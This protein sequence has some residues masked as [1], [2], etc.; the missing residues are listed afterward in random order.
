MPGKVGNLEPVDEFDGQHL[1]RGQGPVHVGHVEV[2]KIR[3]GLGEPFH[4][5]RFQGEIQF[6]DDGALELFADGNGIEDVHA[7]HVFLQQEREVEHDLQIHLDKLFHARAL[8]LHRHLFARLQFRLV[9]LGDG[10]GGDGRFAE[11]PEQ[12]LQRH[13]ELRRH[14]GLG[15]R[16][17]KGRHRVLELFQGGGPFRRQQIRPVAHH[18]AQLDEGGAQFLE[19]GAEAFGPREMCARGARRQT[20]IFGTEIEVFVQVQGVGKIA[21]A[22]LDEDA[23]DLP[24]AVDVPVCFR[25]PAEIA[26]HADTGIRIRLSGSPA[27]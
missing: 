3:R 11:L 12:G 1:A 18:L 16:G 2:G 24:E 19:G 22:V 9:D 26:D 27:P 14:H 6:L 21:E 23:Q 4:L 20:E 7:L 25:Q 17:R 15:F 5:G 8:D 10:G 13:A